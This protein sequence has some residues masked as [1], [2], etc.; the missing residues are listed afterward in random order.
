M[1][2]RAGD[3][4]MGI[5]VTKELGLGFKGEEVANS[6]SLAPVIVYSYNNKLYQQT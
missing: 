2:V 1:T 5:E 6:L 3:N 4:N